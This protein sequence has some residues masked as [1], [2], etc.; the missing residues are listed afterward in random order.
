M[1]SAITRSNNYISNRPD[2]ADDEELEDSNELPAPQTTTNKDGTKTIITWRF[3]DDGK[4]VKTT[5]RI[6]YTKVKEIVNPR[7]AE[8]KE[9][10]KFGLSQKDAAGVSWKNQQFE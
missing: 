3:N 6:R 9:W 5:R 1:P 7:V 4:K 8:R 2:W 10:A